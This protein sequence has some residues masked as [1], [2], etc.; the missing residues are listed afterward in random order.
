MDKETVGESINIDHKN[1][2]KINNHSKPVMEK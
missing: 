1:K 2:T